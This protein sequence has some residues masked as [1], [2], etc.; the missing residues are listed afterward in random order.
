MSMPGSSLPSTATP[1]RRP[2][3]PLLWKS[4]AHGAANH[5]ACKYIEDLIAA[6]AIGGTW[7]LSRPSVGRRH[8]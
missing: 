8:R 5:R 2:I 4:C 7:V 1:P 6:N 3:K